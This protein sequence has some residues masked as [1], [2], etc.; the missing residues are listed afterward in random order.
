LKIAIITPTLSGRGGEETVIN[1]ILR[2][3]KIKL[4]QIA[5]NNLNEF[6][7]VN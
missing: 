1:R 5:R 6:N 7:D 3:R 2:S 4:R